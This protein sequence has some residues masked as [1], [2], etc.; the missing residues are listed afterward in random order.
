[1]AIMKSIL[2]GLW[3]ISCFVAAEKGVYVPAMFVFGDSLGDAGTN[4]YI[5]HCKARANFI[6]YGVSFFPYPTGRFT[7]GR[8]TFDFLAAYMGLPFSPPYLEPKANFS[9]GINFASGG[10]GL[11]DSTAADERLYRAG[12]RKFLLVGIPPIGCC[13]SWRLINKGECLETANQLFVAYNTAMKS[14]L[15]HLNQK[16]SGLT[17]IQFQSYDYLLNIIQNG[18]AYGFKDTKSA[19]CGS[20]LYNAQV[21]CG[22][23]TPKD[24]FCNDSSAYMFWDGAHPTEKVY[25]MF[26][27]EIW[28]GNSSVMYPLNLSTLVPGK[29]ASSY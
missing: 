24:L 29:K 25:A 16:L 26:S 27:Q 18:E 9:R 23:T 13:P 21:H 5:P 15:A 20:G 10:S 8:T 14:H 19:C 7:N 12:A 2:V 6:P 22:K 4:N 11:L 28:S 3:M 1:M 17:I